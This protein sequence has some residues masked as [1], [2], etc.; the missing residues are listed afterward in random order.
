M[1]HRVEIRIAPHA[2]PDQLTEGKWFKQTTK[3]NG[4]KT[5]T[6]FQRDDK[7]RTVG[8]K[9]IDFFSGIKRAKDSVTLTE[10]FKC[11][12]KNTEMGGKFNENLIVP[13]V[14][15]LRAKPAE[16]ALDTAK[17]ASVI[18]SGNYT[19]GLEE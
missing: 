18:R 2:Q 8:Q 3:L 15:Q 14:Q 16:D 10:A 1:T 17:P 7:P 4:V 12:S 6:L 11:I 9:I 5:T 13:A 19:L